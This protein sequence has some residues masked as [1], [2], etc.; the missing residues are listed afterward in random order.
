MTSPRRAALA[1][2]ALLAV[3]SMTAACGDANGGGDGSYGPDRTI[4]V[5]EATVVFPAGANS[6]AYFTLRND[7]PD[8]DRL[9]EV[10]TDV[11]A[12]TEL[13]E[14]RTDDDGLMRMHPVEAVDVP[15]EQALVLAPGGLHAMLLDVERL[16]L[17]DV[18]T[19]ELVFEHGG[20]VVV[21]AEVRS[22]AE[23]FE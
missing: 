6:A 15:A 23:V 3:G 22:S 10:R 7:G 21:S 11:A 12:T 17:G 20:A 4:H 13:H 5:D 16:E 9:V 1:L 14:T 19:L 18:V 8:S 2:A